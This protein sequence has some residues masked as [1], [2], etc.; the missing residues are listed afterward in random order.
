M[1]AERTWSAQR[2]FSLRERAGMSQAKLGADTGFG[3]E[4]INKLERD[5]ISKVGRT[6]TPHYAQKIAPVLAKALKE[7]VDPLHLLPPG[8]NVESPEDPLLLL[9]T[10]SETIGRLEE[11]VDTLEKRVDQLE[12]KRDGGAASRGRAKP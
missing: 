1:G 11:T 8:A 5:G 4:T 2:L 7:P 9:Q 6:M 3:R 10:L 12:R